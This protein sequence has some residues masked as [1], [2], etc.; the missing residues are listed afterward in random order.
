MANPVNEV[1]IYYAVA[2]ANTQRQRN[3]SG[4]I[5]KKRNSSGWKLVSMSTAIVDK[6]TNFQIYNYFGKNKKTS[7][8]PV[9]TTVSRGLTESPPVL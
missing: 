6:K 3:E 1:D 2:N 9:I 5:I 7:K 4:L 8:K